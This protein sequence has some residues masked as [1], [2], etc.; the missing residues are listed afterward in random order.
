MI[1]RDGKIVFCPAAMSSDDKSSGIKN[2]GSESLAAKLIRNTYQVLLTRGM[3]GCFVYCED[4]A[5]NT[6]LKTFIA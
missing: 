6:Y 5:L 3:R 1:Y 2:C 4:S